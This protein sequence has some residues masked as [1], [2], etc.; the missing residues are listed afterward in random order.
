MRNRVRLARSSR[1]LRCWRIFRRAKRW[2]FQ[3]EVAARL[4]I[5]LD[6]CEN[7]KGRLEGWRS[8]PRSIT[9][10]ARAPLKQITALSVPPRTADRTQRSIRP[11]RR[12]QSRILPKIQ[13]I[14]LSRS[15]SSQTSLA[16]AASI[17]RRIRP[18]EV[19]PAVHAEI[20]LH[21]EFVIVP[22]GRFR[23][24]F[25]RRQFCSHPPVASVEIASFIAGSRST[26]IC[27]LLI[28]WLP[29]VFRNRCLECRRGARPSANHRPVCG[30][31][32]TQD[33]PPSTVH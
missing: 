15:G 10:F 6:P 18:L 19:D 28:T 25:W 29:N 20:E 7:S 8:P 3:D 33:P 31:V 24:C 5:N 27:S 11:E 12:R 1:R 30:E 26:V 32:A 4:R 17:A 16:S 2:S 14:A 21:F 9:E 13:V 23:R 22:A